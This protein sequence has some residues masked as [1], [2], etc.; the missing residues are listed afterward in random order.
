VTDDL[1]VQASQAAGVELL[2][3]TQEF[4]AELERL[5]ALAPVEEAERLREI[6]KSCRE[7]A[8]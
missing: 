5:A 7:E 8:P 2:G 4:A 3:E 6:T 1:N